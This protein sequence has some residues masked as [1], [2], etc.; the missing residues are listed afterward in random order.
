MLDFQSNQEK[1][2]YAV[3]GCF[4]S[5]IAVADVEEDQDYEDVLEIDTKPR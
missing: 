3:T 5:V 4:L 2:L 1:V